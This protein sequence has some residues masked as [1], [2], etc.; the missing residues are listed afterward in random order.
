MMRAVCAFAIVLSLTGQAWAA[1]H[2]RECPA[3]APADWGATR[4][5][6]NGVQ[7]LSAKR[8]EVIDEKA[9]PDL[10]PD[11]QRTQAGILHSVW[12]MNADGPDW[13]FQV[14]C[15]YAGA[16]RIL[17]LDALAVKRCEYTTSAA[18]PD[19]PPQQLV[20]D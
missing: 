9:P 12:T 1:G 16:T 15:H 2:A 6:L 5:A 7:V 10:V 20:C 3:T 11:Q 17:K 8:G 18:H 4:G 19:R 13:L 14:W